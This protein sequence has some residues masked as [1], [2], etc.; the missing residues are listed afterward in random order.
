MQHDQYFFNP[1]RIS[2]AQKLVKSDKKP[3]PFILFNIQFT[4]R[5]VYFRKV[6]RSEFSESQMELIKKING[7]SSVK[8]HK[9]FGFMVIDTNIFTNLNLEWLIIAEKEK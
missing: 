9:F 8:F 6:D 3:I 1:A 2:K 5:E 4:K 7:V